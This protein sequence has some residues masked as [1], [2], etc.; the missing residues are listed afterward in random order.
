MLEYIKIFLLITACLVIL[1]TLLRLRNKNIR[2]EVWSF[3]LSSFF[4]TL[5]LA[6]IIEIKPHHFLRTNLKIS[7]LVVYIFYFAIVGYY[8]LRYIKMVLKYK[9]VLIIISYVFFGLANAVD[10]LSDGKL[11]I[12]SY[13]EILEDTF[14]ILGILFWIVFFIDYAKMLRVNF[15]S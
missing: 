4:L 3:L 6:I 8:F 10:L 9:Y 14:H 5:F 12:F 15:N 2:G 1:L 7:N 11:I 13:N